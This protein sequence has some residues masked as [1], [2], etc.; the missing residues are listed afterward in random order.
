MA[1]GG[2]IVQSKQRSQS[3]AEEAPDLPNVVW[4]KHTGLIKL[5]LLL[6]IVISSSATTGFDGITLSL[7]NSR[8]SSVSF[9]S[10]L[11]IILVFLLTLVFRTLF[12]I[13][14]SC[15]RVLTCRIVDERVAVFRPMEKLLWKSQWRAP[16]S[17]Q[18][19]LPRWVY[20]RNAHF[21]L[22]RR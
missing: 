20:G 21:P 5:Y 19:D 3:A 13:I 1:V 11:P 2:A 12:E 8:G 10:F 7:S 16:R 22:H 17:P 9:R 4:W 15:D 14:S 18:R 6:L